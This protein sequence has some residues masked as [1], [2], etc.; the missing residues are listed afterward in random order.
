[1]EV[2]N[3]SIT[4]FICRYWK[5]IIF[6]FFVISI[7]A[8]FL[9]ILYSLVVREKF[10]LPGTLSGPW[11]PIYGTTF[12]ILLFFVESKDSRIYNFVKIFVIASIVEYLSS[13]ISGE[14]FHNVIWDYSNR[15]ININGRICFGMSFL[16]GIMGYVMMYYIEPRIRR[17][18]LFLN[19]K[20][21]IF[22]ILFTSLF[23]LDIFINIFF[24]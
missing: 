22:N 1:M 3:S 14:I 16:F 19:Q 23:I 20:V 9:E 2:L 13:F 10:V 15:F 11:C 21:T 18:F 4:K 12:L 24:I 6:S 8:W 7:G 17:V 5:Y